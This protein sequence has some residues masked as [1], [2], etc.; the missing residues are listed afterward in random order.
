[1]RSDERKRV[2]N[3]TYLAGVRTAIK[4]LRT[5]LRTDKPEK[6]TINTQFKLAQIKLSKAAQKGIIHKNR[7]SRLISRLHHAVKTATGEAQ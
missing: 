1:M 4:D 3:K 2:Y 5:N 6:E 7:A